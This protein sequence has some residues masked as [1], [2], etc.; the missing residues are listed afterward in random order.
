MAAS[1][2]HESFRSPRGVPAR[3]TAKINRSHQAPEGPRKVIPRHVAACQHSPDTRERWWIYTWKREAPEV[4]QRVPYC[5]ESWRCEECRRHEAAVLFARMKQAT[6]KLDPRGWCLLVL[7]LDRDGHYGGKPWRDP[8]Q[9]YGAMGELSRKAL[10]AIGRI[11]GDETRLEHCGGRS[12]TVRTVRT[13]G[14]KWCAVVEAHRS[15]WPHLNVVLW[16]PELAEHL[17]NE[18]AA[19]LDDPDIANAVALARDAWRNKEPVPHDVRELARKATVIGGQ[20]GALIEAAGWGKQSTAEAA[21]DI[22]SVT[23]YIVKLAGLHEGSIGELAKFCQ[24]PLNAKERFR[25]FRCGRGFLPPRIKD[26]AVTGCLVRRRRVGHRA[27]ELWRGCS[28]EWEVYAV[29][30]PTSPEQAVPIDRATQAELTLIDE[31]ECQRSRNAGKLPAMP[32]IRV[33][34]G[35]KLQHH[36]ET[37][38]H[39]AALRSRRMAGSG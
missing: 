3:P 14:N 29:N 30:A 35:G 23:G 21:R 36:T 28:S 22:D 33:V 11:W 26:P 39:R 24:A 20:L 8:D 4:Q 31:E 19:R 7:T 32:P 25:R 16:C 27:K 13:L 18:E 5:C 12:K 17:R 1:E 6:G 37:S 9:A 2:R 34:L 38:E 15:G 10:A